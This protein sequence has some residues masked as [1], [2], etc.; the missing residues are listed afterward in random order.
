M[1][2]IKGAVKILLDIDGVISAGALEKI[3]SDASLIASAQTK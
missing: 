3:N 1:A 2:K